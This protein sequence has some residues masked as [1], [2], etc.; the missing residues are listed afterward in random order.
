MVYIRHLYRALHGRCL[1]NVKS[2]HFIY[3]KYR[4]CVYS[5]SHKAKVQQINPCQFDFV[6]NKQLSISCVDVNVPHKTYTCLIMMYFLLS[7][8]LIACNTLNFSHK[9]EY[10]YLWFTCQIASFNAHELSHLMVL[11]KSNK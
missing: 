11:T 1:V 4:S 7:L 2:L 10:I 6:V 8:T 3:L 9:I 5:T